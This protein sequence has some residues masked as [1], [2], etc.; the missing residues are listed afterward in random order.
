MSGWP[1]SRRWDPFRDFQREVG[2]LL[3][4]LEPL[5]S[6]RMPRPFPSINLYDAGDRYVLVAEL[7]GVG[8]E[9][10]DLTLTG[11][12]ITLRGE[13]RRPEG[14]TDD[15]YRRQERPHGRWSRSV[16]MPEPIDSR[17]VTAQCAHGLLTVWLPKAEQSR[18]RQIP[19]VAV[20]S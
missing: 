9:D 17:G 5:P 6:W 16:T 19:V 10:V 12:T 18:P 15:S 4:S 8:P 3:Q 14:V 11:E 1:A 13:R 7:P 20:G 2:R